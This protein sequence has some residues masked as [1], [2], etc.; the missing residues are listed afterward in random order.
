MVK[1]L[2]GI[3]ARFILPLIITTLL[4]SSAVFVVSPFVIDQL[5]IRIAEQRGTETIKQVQAIRRYY[6]EFILPK[7]RDVGVKVSVDHKNL[8]RT[9]PPP[10][11]F[12]HDISDVVTNTGVSLKLYSPYPWPNRKDRVLTPFEKQAWDTLVV[13]PNAVLSQLD[14]LKGVPTVRVARA[15][16]FTQQS[17]VDCHNTNPDSP[18]NGWSLGETRG[19]VEIQVDI[20]DFLIQSQNLSNA[21]VGSFGIFAIILLVSSWIAGS[22]ITTP[23]I[24]LKETTLKIVQGNLDTPIPGLKRSDE[25]GDMSHAIKVLK[26]T[27]LER[28]ELSQHEKEADLK[29]QKSAQNI[30]EIAGRFDNNITESFSSISDAVEKM[31]ISSNTLFSDAKDTSDK[32]N[33][34]L[35]SIKQAGENINAVS[36]AG[37]ELSSS[38]NEVFVLVESSRD[39]ASAAAAQAGTTNDRV[40]GLAESAQRIGEVVNLINDIANQTNLLALNATIEAAR[41]GDAGRGFAVV[42]NEVK[43]LANQTAKATEDISAQI[44]AVQQE[45]QQAVEAIRKIS[46]I[47]NKINDIS[48]QVAD[49]VESQNSASR[50]ISHNAIETAIATQKVTEGLNTLAEAASRTGT[51]AENLF[52]D[53]ETLRKQA[54]NMGG[55]IIH[56]L[57]SVK[58]N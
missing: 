17:C 20:A 21:I 27:I 40:E 53:A 16:I 13:E 2:S 32:T 19:V 11:T 56:F 26:E 23:L 48:G 30:Q 44:Q 15:D 47:T 49:S 51:M 12:L 18:I 42:A 29:M 55:E 57:E 22:S 43:N 24:K 37:T 6:N 33:Q 39:I 35:E 46:D 50:E 54:N 5:A 1:Y 41:A 31:Y 34:M 28:D 58:E 7:A 38:I 3:R 4:I 45:T 36:S 25:L 10:A 52:H 14:N 8:E 9:L